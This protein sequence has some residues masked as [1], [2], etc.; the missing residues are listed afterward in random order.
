MTDAQR[1][2]KN[3]YAK[4]WRAANP[5]KVRA[6]NVERY[7]THRAEYRARY[8]KEKREDP[9]RFA[10]YR[11]KERVKLKRSVIDMY[12]G[13]CAGCGFSDIACLSI[14]HINGDGYRERKT[15]EGY[16]FYRHL[17]K[18]PRRI[19]LRVLCMNCQFMARAYGS[20][21]RKWPSR[22]TEVR[23][24]LNWTADGPLVETLKYA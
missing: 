12:G 22:I 21:V 13:E 16:K 19:D 2:H 15:I 23:T 4:Q 10:K 24:V 18:T 6:S 8:E 7:A 5:D 17:L 3:D 11:K 9:H 14:D 1:K 20:D